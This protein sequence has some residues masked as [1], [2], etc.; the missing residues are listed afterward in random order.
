MQVIHQRLAVGGVDE[1][2]AGLLAGE[3]RVGR[4]RLVGDGEADD[5]AADADDA[6][7]GLDEVNRGVV[8]DPGDIGLAETTAL[9]SASGSMM[10]LKTIVW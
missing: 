7:P 2:Q 9:A 10:T 3:R 6:L 5:G 4:A 1:R 8:R